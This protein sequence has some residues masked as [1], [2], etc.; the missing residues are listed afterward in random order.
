M[1]GTNGKMVGWNG[2]LT[3]LDT[4][5]GESL[6]TI[7]ADPDRYV[8]VGGGGAGLGTGLIFENDSGTWKNV[9]PDPA[10]QGLVGVYLSSFGDYTVGDQGSVYERTGSTW[11]AVET[12]LGSDLSQTFHSVWIDSSGGIWAAGG[13]PP[14][15]LNRDGI[16]VHRG[17]NVPEGLP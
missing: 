5:S 1:V 6:F 4:G 13:D 12:G 11:R 9:T 14:L 7:H 15:P 8:A 10:P 2:S 16:L 17:A 3:E